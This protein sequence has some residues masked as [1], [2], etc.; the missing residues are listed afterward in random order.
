MPYSPRVVFSLVLYNHSIDI[1]KPLLSSISDLS[2]HSEAAFD[3]ELYVSDNS[4][5]ANS[6]LLTG[7]HQELLSS[8][9]S[10]SS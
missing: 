2:R 6:S 3:V 9:P 1:I 7:I 5:K 4:P 10:S 8:S